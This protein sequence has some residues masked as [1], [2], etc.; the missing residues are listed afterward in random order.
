DPARAAL[1]TLGNTE[2]DLDKLAGCD[3]VIEAVVEQIDPKRALFEQIER[4]A[5][6][7]TIISSN[8]SGIPIRLLA[9]GRSESFRQRFLGTHFFNPPR[10]LHLLELIPTDETSEE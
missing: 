9:E 8:T 3:W 6:P 5:G 1:I 10:Y 4:V 7:E 2:D